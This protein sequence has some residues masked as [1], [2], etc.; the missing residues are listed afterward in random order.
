MNDKF[1]GDYK[2]FLKYG[3]L[4]SIYEV[5]KMETLIVWMKTLDKIS[6]KGD[7]GYLKKPQKY[8]NYNEKLFDEI[9]MLVGDGKRTIEEVQKINTLSKYTFYSEPLNDNI[10]DRE[11][12]FESVY[13]LAGSFSLIFF[14][15][16][17][18]IEIESCKY[19][20]KESSKFI[21][22]KE[23]IKIWDMKKDILIYK[24]FPR[25]EKHYPFAL[26]LIDKCNNKLS[27]VKIMPFV[28][29]DVLFL[30]LTRK[31][32]DIITTIKNTLL[33]RWKNEFKLIVARSKYLAICED[34]ENIYIKPESF[35]NNGNILL[36]II[37]QN[38][39]ERLNSNTKIEWKDF[40]DNRELS[41]ICENQDDDVRILWIDDNPEK[42]IKL[43]NILMGKVIIDFAFSIDEASILI[44]NNNYGFVISM[45]DVDDNIINF[46]NEIRLKN[47][48]MVGSREITDQNIPIIVHY[49][50]EIFDKY[51]E[52][53]KNLNL[54]SVK[55]GNDILR[56]L[57]SILLK[58]GNL[59]EEYKFIYGIF[60]IKK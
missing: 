3:L 57:H 50:K 12:Y 53:I 4:E 51:K 20:R 30:Y 19:G 49:N 55:N 7:I 38:M 56:Y 29:R 1:V 41:P 10:G 59:S 14:D 60:K 23:I 31:S 42:Y 11:K 44:K 40:M 52:S 28:T 46:F 58:I 37:T 33:N 16:D 32:E 15:P 48:K 6:G 36:K 35:K 2:D 25:M 45:L 9:N 26:E 17:N 47:V 13:S 43:I 54:V 22:W 21:Y 18:G 39:F 24:H 8:R 5:T 27:N 34:Y